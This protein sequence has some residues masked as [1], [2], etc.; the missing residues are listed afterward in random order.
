M[1]IPDIENV[2]AIG[3]SISICKISLAMK[4]PVCDRVTIGIAENILFSD[5]LSQMKRHL[6]NLVNSRNSTALVK[7]LSLTSKI[8]KELK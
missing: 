4:Y 1:R 3:Q 7:R 2:K 5:Y 8:L 6:D